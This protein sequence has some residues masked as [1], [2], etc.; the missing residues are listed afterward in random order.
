MIIGDPPY[1][2]IVTLES[3]PYYHCHLSIVTMCLSLLA[4]RLCS[5]INLSSKNN[6]LGQFVSANV[7]NL[8]QCEECPIIFSIEAS[9][10]LWREKKEVVKSLRLS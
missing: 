4:T 2:T 6:E 7:K 5:D 8:G 3:P 9:C 10:C 1:I